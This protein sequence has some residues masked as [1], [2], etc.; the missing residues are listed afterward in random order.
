MQQYLE[1]KE[2]ST[3]HRHI[4]RGVFF[5]LEDSVSVVFLQTH[6]IS[7]DLPNF[8]YLKLFMSILFKNNLGLLSQQNMD[9]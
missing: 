5:V 6:K 9:Y 7:T 3:E 1:I 4:S 8:S 2:E